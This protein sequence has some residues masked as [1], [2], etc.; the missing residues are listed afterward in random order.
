MNWQNELAAAGFDFDKVARCTLKTKKK[1]N[2]IWMQVAKK[3]GS[4]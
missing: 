2:K 3:D 1:G 4:A